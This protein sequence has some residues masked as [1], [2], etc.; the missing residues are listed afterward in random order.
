MIPQPLLPPVLD[1]CTKVP[2][3]KKLTEPYSRQSVTLFARIHCIFTKESTNK[4]KDLQ[5]LFDLVKNL[6]LWIYGFMDLNLDFWI[7]GF[8][9]LWILKLLLVK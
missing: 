1:S 5:A 3:P 7:S 8:M 2:S 4:S 9:D 6:D